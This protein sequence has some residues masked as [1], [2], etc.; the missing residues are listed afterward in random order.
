MMKFFLSALL[1]AGGALA[2][3]PPDSISNKD[4]KDTVY[5]EIKREQIKPDTGLT[6]KEIIEK[7][8][9]AIGGKEKIY[10][11]SDRITVMKGTVQGVKITIISY[12][13]APN[14]LK[15][16]IN[17]GNNK[18]VIIFNGKEGI[19]KMAGETR[20]ITGSELEKLKFESTLT[21][22]TDP[23]YHGVKLNLEGI[24]KVEN[25]NAY[26]VIMT[27]PSGIKWTQYYDLKSGLKLKEQK[28]INSP[29]GLLLQEIT[30]NDYRE[31]E[32]ILYPYKI[33]QS[34]GFQTMEF[35]VSSI[36]INTGLV[37]REFKIE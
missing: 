34:I 6:A 2:S 1:L 28:Y 36:K 24:E 3:T 7:Y 14:K 4:K 20:E 27:L 9:S 23:E 35:T 16:R 37:D 19:M 5:S 11:I 15:Q 29:T 21:L 10:S 12:Q 25:K 13:K 8:I 32:G 33:T 17:A 22:L 18:Q 30:Y 26:K 31:V